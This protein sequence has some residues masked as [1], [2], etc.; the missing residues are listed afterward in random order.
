[1]ILFMLKEILEKE[2]MSQNQFSKISD[3]RPNTINNICNDNLKRL[4]LSTFDKIL[5]TLVS[6]GYEIEDI[7]QYKKE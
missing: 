4:E 6:M 3:V 5:K 1:M 2:N 7:I